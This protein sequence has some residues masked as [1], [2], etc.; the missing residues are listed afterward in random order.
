MKEMRLI[1]MR[2]IREGEG[3]EETEPEKVNREKRT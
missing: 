2:E 1:F 3:D